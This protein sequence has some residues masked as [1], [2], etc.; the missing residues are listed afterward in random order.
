MRRVLC[1]TAVI[2]FLASLGAAINVGLST[3]ASPD[4]DSQAEETLVESADSDDLIVHEWGTF[5]SFSGSD[6]VKLEFRPLVDNDLPAFVNTIRPTF[7]RMLSKRSIRAIQRMETPVTYFYT[8]VERDIA[9]KVEFPQGLLTEYYP[10]VRD[11]RLP[12][13]SVPDPTPYGD[14]LANIPLKDGMLDWG[15]IHLIPP[16]SLRA[17]VEDKE[18]SR[19]IGRQ[20]EQVMVEPARRFP[21]YFAARNTD[22]A[23]VQMRTGTAP[24][25]VDYFEKFLFYRGVGNFELPLTLSEAEDDTFQLINAGDDEIRSVFLVAVENKQ[26]RFH[27]YDASAPHSTMTLNPESLSGEI[28]SLSEAMTAALV[29]EGLYEKEARAMIAC[30]RSSWF[31]EEGTRLLY[32]VPTSITEDLLPLQISPKPDEVVRVLVG[33]MEIMPKSEEQR[34]LGLVRASAAMRPENPTGKGEFRS[35]SLK[36]LLAMGRLAEPALVRV[37]NVTDNQQIREEAKRLIVELRPP[38]N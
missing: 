24:N 14:S 23:I 4:L 11:I 21:H 25:V 32:M 36:E 22:A 35:P 28:E 31:G 13:E 29:D 1:L 6:G 38:S 27:R 33:R 37:Q 8:P 7:D 2:L 3:A 15:Q 5:T 26:L 16:K 10:P 34:I 9:A 19:R 30:W 20:V 18:L 12:Q 17:P